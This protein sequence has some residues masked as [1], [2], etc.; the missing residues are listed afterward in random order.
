MPANHLWVRNASCKWITGQEVLQSTAAQSSSL[1]IFAVSRT[2]IYNSIMS[3]ICVLRAYTHFHGL[4]MH[5]HTCV[6][7][8]TIYDSFP[9]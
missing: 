5:V 8:N 3:C 2:F 4:L 9:L 6:E 7:F 1:Y